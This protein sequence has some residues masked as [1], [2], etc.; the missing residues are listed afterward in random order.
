MSKSYGAAGDSPKTPPAITSLSVSGFK[1]IVEEQT[2]EIRPLTLLAGANGSGKSSMMQPLLL[3]K[4]TL[5]APYDPG[6]L[7]LDGPNVRFTSAR[8]FRPIGSPRGEVVPFMVW[9]DLSD[10]TGFVVTFLGHENE[11]IDPGLD[12]ITGF[13]KPII[14]DTKI[15]A[16]DLVSFAPP[17]LPD[18]LLRKTDDILRKM[19]ARR[20]KTRFRAARDR[21]F[22]RIDPEYNSDVFVYIINYDMFTME[23][24]SD[25]IGIDPS[26]RS[27]G[28][29]RT[30]LFG[31][32][33]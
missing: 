10:D 22:L 25:D 12:V 8:Q 24:R 26:A 20:G 15:R 14:I 31:H 3:L 29:P 18:D 27:A 5:E 4:Q 19:K 28:Q 6:P 9:L 23:G 16:D 21:F 30:D 17:S 7:L 11:P 2:L 1:S 32:R 13:K 33:G